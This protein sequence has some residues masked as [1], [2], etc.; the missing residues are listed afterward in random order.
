MHSNKAKKTEVLE[1]LRH[2]TGADSELTSPEE[3]QQTASDLQRNR[4]RLNRYVYCLHQKHYNGMTIRQALGWIIAYPHSPELEF[5]WT[6]PDVHSAEEW[7]ALQSQV[8]ELGT[9]LREIG[10]L[11][12]HPLK[13]VQTQEWSNAWQQK[14]LEKSHS[15][16][17]LIIKIKDDL[18]L[19]ESKINAPLNELSLSQFPALQML[20]SQLQNLPNQPLDFAFS[21]YAHNVLETGQQALSQ[22]ERY[23]KIQSDLSCS[24]STHSFQKIPLSDCQAWWGQSLQ[25]WW[26]R[27]AL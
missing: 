24:Y 6:S 10:V 19:I 27:S 23:Q 2:A 12:N 21:P 3:W 4:E 18:K 14:T 26:P 5:S 11:L 25:A 8:K 16:R 1:Q 17:N 7:K 20:C 22:L 13:W 15:L 9:V